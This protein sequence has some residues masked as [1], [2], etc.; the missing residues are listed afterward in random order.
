MENENENE[1][2]III[3]R[4]MT[5]EEKAERAKWAKEEPAR[6]KAIAEDERRQGYQRISDPVFFMWQRGEKT[7]QDWKDAITEVNKL[8]PIPGEES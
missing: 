6:L 4:P 5:K 3:E 1:G 8:Y 7:E 2:T